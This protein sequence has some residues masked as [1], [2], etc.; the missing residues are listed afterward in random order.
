MA[1]FFTDEIFTCSC[2]SMLFEEKEVKSFKLAGKRL[3]DNTTT[4]IIKC[5]TCGKETAINSDDEILE[6]A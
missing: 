6:Q 4:K 5:Q 2:G 3:V 1:N